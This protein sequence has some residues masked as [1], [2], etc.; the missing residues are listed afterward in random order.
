MSAPGITQNERLVYVLPR[1]RLSGTAYRQERFSISKADCLPDEPPSWDE[2]IRLP[3]P[4]W[5]DIYRQF[6]YQHREEP[7]EPARGTLVISS[8]ESWL[9]T[10]ASKL[11]A[12]VYVMGIE[13]SQWRVPADAFVYSS[14][15]ATSDP[16]D[17]VTLYT[18]TG[19][20]TEDLGS[21][22]LTPP[23]ELRAIS[24]SF[25]VDLRKPEHVE[26]VRRFDENPYDRLATACYHLFR[27]QFDNPVV[28]SAE[29]DFAAFC[30][31][32][33][34]AFDIHG[35]DY[36]KE[37]TDR[38]TELY[39]D[40]PKLER[41]I[42]GLY[43][44][45]SVFNHGIAAEPTMTCSD[46]RVKAL[47]EFRERN[48][49]WDVLRKLCLDVIL[50]QLQDSIE[51]SRRGLARPMNPMTT[52]L[53]QFFDSETIWDEIARVCTQAKSVEKILAFSGSDHDDFVELCCAFLNGHRGQAMKGKADNKKVL[54]VLMTMAAVYGE[55][56]KRKQIDADVR[57]ADHLFQ[58]AKAGNLDAI[59]SWAREHA[60]WGE[61]LAVEN[62]GDAAKAAAVHTAMFF[63]RT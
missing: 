42:K 63:V 1:I 31:C 9:R 48:L 10:H 46:D 22:Q 6:P 50:D 47:L 5:L 37:L 27:S 16:H 35:P 25:R 12:V 29:Q 45:R 49:N 13:E 23:L 19:G 21:L 11:F 52:L 18:K 56:A 28:A 54:A 41:W 59:D 7:A 34:A 32:L 20:K 61:L 53:R 33:E 2:V 40:H 36:S 55:L 26:L 8:D 14:F 44:E 30:A 15:K 4:D 58:A 51:A 3:R 39:G 62:I 17:L 24:S 38:I 60:S 43:S 57:S